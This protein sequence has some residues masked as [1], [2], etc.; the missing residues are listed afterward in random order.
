MS[1]AGSLVGGIFLTLVP[2]LLAGA[3]DWVPILYGGALLAVVLGVN[4]LP[5]S[6]RARLE[7]GHS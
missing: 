5:A 1:F 3:G 7:G 6:V 4:A 2:L